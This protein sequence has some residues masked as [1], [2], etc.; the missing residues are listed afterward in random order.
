MLYAL[1]VE[2]YL[3]ECI[4]TGGEALKEKNEYSK[5]LIACFIGYIVQ[6]IVNNFAPLLFLT[7]RREFGIPLSQITWLIT[8]NFG[9]QLAVDALSPAF[10]DRIG[11]RAAM[12]LGHAVSALGFVCLAF[13]PDL[14]PSPFAGLTVCVTL[15]AVGGGIMEVLVSPIVEACPTDN[16]Q[17]AMSL[18]HSFYCWGQAGTV[19]VSTVFFALAGVGSWRVL[20]LIWAAVP[21]LNMLLFARVPINTLIPEGE[22]GRSLSSLIK[23]KAF[24]LFVIMMLC[25]GACELT[26]SQW[27]SAFAEAGLHVSKQT[28]DL[29]GPMGF[30]LLMGSAR[31][32]FGKYGEKMS[33]KRFMAASAVLCLICYLVIGLTDSAAAGLIGCMVCGFSV[34]I[35]WPGTFSIASSRIPNGATL[36][37]ALLALAGDLGCGGGPTLAGRLSSLFGDDLHKGILCACIFP[38]VMLVCVLILGRDKRGI[39]KT[40]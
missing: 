25:A 7:F 21:V 26:V 23:D 15:Y 10:V 17:T 30:A 33:L 32:I 37:F 19:L 27:A 39:V 34:G 14:L 28:G 1:W 12:L 24:W 8:I 13:L 4:M 11:Y 29:L 38:A 31:A 3:G 16:K 9:V 35:F 5:T 2:A 22:Q 20:A 6:A 18:L 40:H 36:M